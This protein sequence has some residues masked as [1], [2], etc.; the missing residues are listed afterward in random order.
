MQ[1][2]NCQKRALAVKQCFAAKITTL[3][4]SAPLVWNLARE[5]FIARFVPGLFKSRNAPFCE[6]AQHLND[7]AK[8]ASN[9][10]L[11]QDVFR[12]VDLD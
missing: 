9:G 1:F 3:L 4:H 12:G 2:L 8:L 10:T 11:L 5:K 6:A 7:G